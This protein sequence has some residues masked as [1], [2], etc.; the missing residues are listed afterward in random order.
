MLMLSRGSAEALAVVGDS[1]GKLIALE[2]GRTIPFEIKRVYYLFD[3]SPELPR[4]F[5]AHR[6]LQQLAICVAGRCKFI[7]DDGTSRREIWLES[8]DQSLHI[9]NMVWREMH[10]FSRDCVLLVLAS[11]LYDEADYIRDYDTF[12]SMLPS[13]A[14]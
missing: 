3:L 5:H 14:P 12:R 2:A 1:R 4:G 6:K 9:G 7:L 13:A 8:P 11:E 10:D